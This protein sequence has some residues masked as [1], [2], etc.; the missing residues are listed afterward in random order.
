ML[1]SLFLGY[2]IFLWLILMVPGYILQYFPEN[3][4]MGDRFFWE[5]ACLKR[6]FILLV[7]IINSLAGCRNL[8]WKSFLL[9]MLQTLPYCRLALRNG[10]PF[11]YLTPLLPNLF[12][13]LWNLLELLLS[14]LWWFLF[15][16]FNFLMMSLIYSPNILLNF[17]Y[18]PSYL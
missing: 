9:R 7:P 11:K 6:L 4:H 1:N 12:V 8:G 17:S 5:L 2:H 10:L 14:H 13:S 3:Q 16:N 18:L 15:K